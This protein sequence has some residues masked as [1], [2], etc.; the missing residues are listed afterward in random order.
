M[1]PAKKTTTTETISAKDHL[2]SPI[3]YIHLTSVTLDV[4]L[5]L[6]SFLLYCHTLQ[7]DA[8][9]KK[10]TIAFYVAVIVHYG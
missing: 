1:F 3:I 5:V 9:M 4:N 8:D 6:S 10:K 2:L 7:I